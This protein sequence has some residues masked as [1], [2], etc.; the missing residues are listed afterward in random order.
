M[1]RRDVK[2]GKGKIK[3]IA[4]FSRK[5]WDNGKLMT[6]ADKIFLK[7]KKTSFELA[8]KDIISVEIAKHRMI[9]ILK[10]TMQN[11]DYYNVSSIVE[12]PAVLVADEDYFRRIEAETE[13]ANERLY[14][15]LNE[16][17]NP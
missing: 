7:G 15:A 4:S 5:Y 3:G 2:F 12:E 10:I 16:F 1:I 17:L 6:N 9:K 11:D 14:V 13:A 8:T